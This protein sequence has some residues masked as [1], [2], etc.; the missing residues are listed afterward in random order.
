LAAFCFNKTLCFS[1]V[2]VDLTSIIT[3]NSVDNVLLDISGFDIE[4]LRKS[5]IFKHDLSENIIQF[6]TYYEEGIINSLK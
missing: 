3:T 1:K 2:Q 4:E 5:P 6:D